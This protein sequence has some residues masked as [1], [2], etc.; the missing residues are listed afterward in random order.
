VLRPAL[1]VGLAA[2]G[3]PP[4]HPA[5]AEALAELLAGHLAATSLQWPWERWAA[6]AEQRRAAPQRR[7]VE[8]VLRRLL[9]L[10]YHARVAAS[11][12]AQL[13]PL[14]GSAPAPEAGWPYGGEAGVAPTPGAEADSAR[15]L[16]ALARAK[17]PAADMTAA[18]LAVA[19]HLAG[20]RAVALSV[21]DQYAA[22]AP[23]DRERIA[24]YE[25]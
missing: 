20:H 15:S 25:H 3:A 7:F 14:L 24:R 1:E 18:A 21:L 6:V 23:E 9:R 19:H 16:L 13:Q 12:P 11:L 10:S 4:E 22:I 2:L 17:A 8:D 5:A